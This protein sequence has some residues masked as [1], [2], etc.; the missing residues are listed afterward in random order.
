MT[1]TRFFIYGLLI[2]LTIGAFA[3]E[4]HILKGTPRNLEETFVSLNQLFNDTVKYDFMTLPEEIST[5]RRHRS[6]GMWMRNHWGLWGN[7]ELKKYFVDRGIHHPDNMT[8]VILSSY[9][10][11]LNNKP[12]E[13]YIKGE[14]GKALPIDS[15]AYSTAALLRHIDSLQRQLPGF[16]PIGDTVLAYLPAIEKKLFKTK[17]SSVKTI[18]SVNE[19]RKDK[20]LIQVISI[21]E[22]GNKV[23]L[24]QVGDTLEV[25]PENCSLL[26]PKGWTFE[27]GNTWKTN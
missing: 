20:L 24:K 6:L 23:P 5:S 18:A 21:H 7:S 13:F 10:Q 19:Y 26:P 14:N 12:I 9:H 1:K 15:A 3:Q 17:A 27:K 8:S 4:K 2:L 22:A 25:R 11:Y 16:Y